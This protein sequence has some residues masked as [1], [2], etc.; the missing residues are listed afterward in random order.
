METT[1]RTTGYK[2]TPILGY[3]CSRNIGYYIM[4]NSSNQLEEEILE[5][6]EENKK[7]LLEN[8]RLKEEVES[9]WYLLD[10]IKKSDIREHEHLLKEL[11]KDVA[12]KALMY[13][14]KKGYA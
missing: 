1:L 11:E 7:L 12:L 6:V 10:E 8:E 5:L 3:T 4:T 2:R 14:N 13:T 9:L